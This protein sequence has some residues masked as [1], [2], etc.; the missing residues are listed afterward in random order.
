M[1][2]TLVSWC[3]IM[4][5]FIRE[6]NIIHFR[7]LLETTTDET[8]RRTLYRLIAE[9]EAKAPAPLKAQEDVA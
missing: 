1:L 9:E 8:E 2:W 6:Q 3:K 4:Q 7:K 5:E